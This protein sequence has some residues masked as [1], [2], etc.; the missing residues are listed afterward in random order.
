MAEGEGGADVLRIIISSGLPCGKYL[1]FCWVETSV[2]FHVSYELQ[3]CAVVGCWERG[4]G[5]NGMNKV[6]LDE[7]RER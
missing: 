7:M 4:G 2:R 5:M 3:C 6:S 1:R